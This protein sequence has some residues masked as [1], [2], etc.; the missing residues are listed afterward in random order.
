MTALTQYERLESGGLWRARPQDQRRDVV[1]SFGSATLVISDAAD[2]PLAH[3]SLPAVARLN[4]GER[5]ALFAPD[6][7]ASETLEIEDALMI[8]A[9]ETVR[10][11]LLTA[12]P[13]QGRLRWLASASLMAAIV[14]LGVFWVPGMLRQQTLSVVPDVK[15]SEMGAT[16]LGHLQAATGPAC[17]SA[18]GRAALQGLHR[19]LFGPGAEGQIVILPSGFG[20]ATLLP[21]QI[22]VMDAGVLG[23]ADDPLIPASVVLATAA[24]GTVHD[25]L[26]D[27]LNAA[28]LGETVTL[29]TTGELPDAVLADYAADLLDGRRFAPDPAVVQAA[30]VHAGLPVEPYAETV[31]SAPA[32]L[33]DSPRIE[34]SAIMSD[35]D[36]V[37]LQGICNR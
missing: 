19:R 37:S 18:R 34:A 1:V 24:T 33:T 6:A 30:F 5:P 31:P 28:G 13:V 20:P 25:P 15:R 4:P 17:R 3:W 35:A 8:E 26:G 29:L 32:G 23:L 12:Q 16:I 2:R 10:K 27:V 14:G 22:I 21:G 7:D 11:S 36:W 9:I